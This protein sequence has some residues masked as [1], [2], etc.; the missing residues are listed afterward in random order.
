MK[1]F[2]K[3]VGKKCYLSP[4]DVS[5]AERYT[6]WLNDIE[7]IKY[8]TLRDKMVSLVTERE[9]LERL[10]RGHSYAIV[11][12]ESDELIGSCGLVD[13][14]YLNR[15]CEVGIFIGN[16]E[17]WG[18]GYGTEALKL[19]I[20]YGINYLNLNNFML[21]VYSY[22]ERAIKSYRKIGFREMGRRRKSVIIEG[23]EY[24]TI[25]MDLLAEEFE[26]IL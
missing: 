15:T 3:L 6:E 7:V 17:Y 12:L 23:K 11:T 1:Y 14:D 24:D 22:N 20:S 4:I 9:A 2:K 19:L 21:K 16:K 8:L 5:D 10:A 13:V 18:K 26:S 25:Y